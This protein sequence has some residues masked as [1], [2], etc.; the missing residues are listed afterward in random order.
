MRA[1]LF[2]TATWALFSAQPP[3]RAAAQSPLPIP[4]DPAAVARARADSARYPYTAAD[5]EFFTGMIPH[6][7]QAVLMATMAPSHAAGPAVMRLAERIVNAQV[8]EIRLMQ[9]W[10][11][12]RGQ[13]VPDPLSS[14]DDHPMHIG[15]LMPGMLTPEQLGTLDAAR[16]RDF[17]RHFLSF[18]IQ[19][20]QGAVQMVT[21]LFAAEGGRDLTVFKL[22]SDIHVDQITEIRRMQQ[23]LADLLLSRGTEP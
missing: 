8:D 5:I 22:A 10:L 9:T 13:R 14:R 21:A 7:A 11:L 1:S 18:M 12:D 20:H 6:H 3:D 4:P 23:M 16:G 15:P 2:L 17:D 19:H